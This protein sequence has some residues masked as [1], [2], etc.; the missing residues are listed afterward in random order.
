MLVSEAFIVVSLI[1]V[2]AVGSPVLPDDL[3]YAD[4]WL[5]SLPGHLLVQV[6]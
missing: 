1:I 3:L 5:R 2:T 4:N 6:C